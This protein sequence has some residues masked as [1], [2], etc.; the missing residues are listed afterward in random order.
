LLFSLFFALFFYCLVGKVESSQ[1]AENA[2]SLPIGLKQ[3][4][5]PRVIHSAKNTW[6]TTM[7]A[8]IVKTYPNKYAMKNSDRVCVCIAPVFWGCQIQ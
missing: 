8:S 3:S 7:T 2:Q 4:D 6:I 1:P 5:M